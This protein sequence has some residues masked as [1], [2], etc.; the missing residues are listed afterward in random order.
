MTFLLPHIKLSGVFERRTATGNKVFSHFISLHVITFVL[1]TFITLIETICP[2]M[3][4]KLQP[5]NV[6]CPFPVAIELLVLTGNATR[7]LNEALKYI[8]VNNDRCEGKQIAKTKLSLRR[9]CFGR[10]EPL[11][12]PSKLHWPF[13]T[14]GILS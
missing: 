6:K 2:K 9:H 5:K 1:I 11:K 10:L 8:T 3:C 14:Q 13:R 12:L 7:Y 4:T